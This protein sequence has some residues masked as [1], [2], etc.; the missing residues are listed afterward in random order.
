MGDVRRDSAAVVPLPS[1]ETPS[2]A[3]DE[4][5]ADQKAS[6]SP[7]P[8]RRARG[9]PPRAATNEPRRRGQL[10]PLRDRPATSLEGRPPRPPRSDDHRI[11]ERGGKVAVQGASGRLVALP[12][13]RELPAVDRGRHLTQ[14]GQDE[15]N[16]RLY[17]AQ[18]ERLL[19]REQ[20]E[21]ELRHSMLKC[22]VRVLQ[23]D[24]EDALLQRIYA[25]SAE[26]ERACMH[27]LLQKWREPKESRKFTADDQRESTNRMYKDRCE[28]RAQTR[29]ALRAKYIDGT[30]PVFRKLTR[31]E[32]QK[33]IEKL[34]VR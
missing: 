23:R 19:V 3:E 28:K 8:G 11:I 26:R 27:R 24:D 16:N 13:R 32:Q 25:Q 15:L 18:L 14:G 34:Y 30:K 1:E 22:P 9:S 2:Q 10:S 17:K 4:P 5:A 12:P 7:S 31:A 33:C 6:Q 20:R 21:A 29:E